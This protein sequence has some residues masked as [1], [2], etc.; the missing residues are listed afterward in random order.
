MGIRG[1]DMIISTTTE[2]PNLTI[3]EYT[4]WLTPRH[5][6]DNIATIIISTVSE[7]EKRFRREI[8]ELFK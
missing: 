8:N 7:K 4:E 5:I 3:P 1:V 6:K 2:Q